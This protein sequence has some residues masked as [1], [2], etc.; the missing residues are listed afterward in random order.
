[1][2]NCNYFKLFYFKNDTYKIKQNFDQV[3][4]YIIQKLMK[5]DNISL[6]GSIDFLSNEQ[7]QKQRPRKR[8]SL[9]VKKI[10]LSIQKDIKSNF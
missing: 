4:F 7:P 8:S 2:Y 5:Q 10:P 9:K 3:F 1:M 6:K